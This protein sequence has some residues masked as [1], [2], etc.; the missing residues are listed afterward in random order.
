[1]FQEN[2]NYGYRRNVWGLKPIAIVVCLASATASGA[3]LWHI[4][5]TTGKF[6]EALATAAI[7]SVVLLLL[8]LFRFTANWVRVPAEAYAQRLAESVEILSAHL[9]TKRPG[10]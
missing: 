7:F 4:R 1:L 9:S 10:E 3:S 2:V 8:W 5:Q 6:D